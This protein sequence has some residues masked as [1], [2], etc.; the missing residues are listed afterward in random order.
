MDG[1]GFGVWA[2]HIP[3]FKEDLQLSSLSLS[4]VL[5][6]LVVGSII[7]MPLAGRAIARFGSRRIVWIGCTAYLLS[8][9]GLGLV[10]SLWPLVWMAGVF[11][12]SKGALDISVNAQ[13]VW[14]EKLVGKPIVSSFQGFWSLGGLFGASITSFALHHGGNTHQDF[15]RTAA[16][17]GVCSIAGAQ[18]LRSGDRQA[19]I[20]KKRWQLPDATLLRLAGIAFL[21]LFAEG[22]MSDWGGVF[23]KTSVGVSLAQAAIG[24]AA[25]SLS[26]A[27]G[28]FFG[29]WLIARFDSIAVLRVCGLLLFCGLSFALALNTWWASLAGFI[30]AGFG[31]A[32]IVPV[33]WGTAGRNSAIGAGPAI[34]TVATVGYFGFLAGPP[35]I[36]VLA[37][38]LSVR[39]ALVIVGVF[40]LLIAGYARVATEPRQSIE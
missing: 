27:A 10:S 22:A 15:L 17:L 39:L 1:F 16:M 38:A 2:G 7:T 31:V 18:L 29:D 40:G 36:G 23:L 6:A 33:I 3:V 19:V 14:V 24:Y 8:I 35:L 21:G 37:T 25:F 20:E 32:N 4:E 9:A 30:C 11:G 34:A 13:G 28:R 26:M 5:L 12:A